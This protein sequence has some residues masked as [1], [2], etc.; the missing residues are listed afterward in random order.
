M[1]IPAAYLDRIRAILPTLVVTSTHFNQDGMLNDV[2]TLNEQFIARFPKN[3]Y[4]KERLVRESVL[5]ELIRAA[6]EMPVPQFE[7]QAGDV[8]MYRMLVG[9]PLTREVLLRTSSSQRSRGVS[10][11]CAL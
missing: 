2:V 11:A 10:N 8:V 1:D 5:L 6:V 4:A 3:A 9:E 7:Y